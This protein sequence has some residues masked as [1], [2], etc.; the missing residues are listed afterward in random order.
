[1]LDAIARFD[2]VVMQAV[3]SW[4]Q[5][6]HPLMYGLS[7]I[8]RPIFTIMTIGIVGA[9]A[10]TRHH[11]PLLVSAAVASATF[12][13][14]SLLKAVVH[15]ERPST[16]ES[17][18]VLIQTFSFPSGH[19][20]SSVV[21]FGMLAYMAWRLLPQPWGA[22][23]AGIIALVIIG[24]GISRVYLGAHYPSDVIV[25]WIVGAI[26]LAIIIWAVRPP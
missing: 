24:I 19:A 20:A 16:Y 2:A 21:V 10:L 22:V 26:G 14:N 1:M 17:H 6:L 11:F 12:A 25:G 9:F 18:D 3:M 8:G 13:L 15:R 23:V 4:P 5:W 7:F